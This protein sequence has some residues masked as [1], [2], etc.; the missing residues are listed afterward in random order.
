MVGKA[1]VL[2][3]TLTMAR[4]CSSVPKRLGCVTVSHEWY[5]DP[6]PKGAK[7]N[8][9]VINFFQFVKMWAVKKGAH[10]GC[11]VL[12]CGIFVCLVDNS[13]YGGAKNIIN[14]VLSVG[15]NKAK[16]WDLESC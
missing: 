5:R 9:V 1:Q 13:V 3:L 11:V 8:S 14:T 6:E 2:Q 15:T 10:C 16:P 12:C 7:W 4:F